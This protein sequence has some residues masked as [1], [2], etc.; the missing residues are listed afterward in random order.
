VKGGGTLSAVG[1]APQSATARSDPSGGQASTYDH[2]STGVYKG[3]SVF[4]CGE[5]TLV[6]D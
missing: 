6:A 2:S 3:T 1:F 4:C 5:K